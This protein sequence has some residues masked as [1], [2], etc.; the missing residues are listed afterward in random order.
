MKKSVSLWESDEELD[1]TY[2]NSNSDSST[3]ANKRNITSFNG[4]NVSFPI[5]ANISDFSTNLVNGVGSLFSSSAKAISLGVGSILPTTVSNSTTA[6]IT[7]AKRDKDVDNISKASMVINS[8]TANDGKVKSMDWESD[9]SDGSYKTL[10]FVER[11]HRKEL[12][13]L[14]LDLRQQVLQLQL[15]LQASNSKNS[16]SNTDAVSN[17]DGSSSGTITIKPIN[18][19]KVRASLF[20]SDEDNTQISVPKSSKGSDDNNFSVKNE[21]WEKMVSEEKDRRARF[22]NIKQN[23]RRSSAQKVSSRSATNKKVVEADDAQNLTLSKVAASKGARNVS[24]LFGSSSEEDNKSSAVRKAGDTNAND[25]SSSKVTTTKA[26]TIK[27]VKSD[28]WDNSD[29]ESPRVAGTDKSEETGILKTTSANKLQMDPH[30][31]VLAEKDKDRKKKSR[32]IV[33]DRNKARPIRAQINLS[34][35]SKANDI[36]SN[37]ATAPVSINLGGLQV[38]SPA[39][40][41]AFYSSES[42][43]DSSSNEVSESVAEKLILKDTLSGEDTHKSSNSDR[44][45]SCKSGEANYEEID[46]MLFSWVQ[47]KSFPQ[48]LQSVRS[49]YFDPTSLPSLGALWETPPELLDDVVTDADVRKAYL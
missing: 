19:E 43:W 1:N 29:E 13:K 36:A 4:G 17:K 31:S 48:L 44:I 46:A 18:N 14:V 23:A 21:L 45:R 42:E 15:Q 40:F 5:D 33:R 39:P 34:V 11:K 8:T 9:S 22:R 30:W 16:N 7:S 38:Q 27:I 41:D 25:N 10:Y 20:D 49:V 2:S 37:G 35:K 32:H 24:D 28:L 26:A 47:G 6:T 12:E 3:A